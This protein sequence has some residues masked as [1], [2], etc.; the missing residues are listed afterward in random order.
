MKATHD[1][2]LVVGMLI[3]KRDM[4]EERARIVFLDDSEDLREL[5]PILLEGALRVE[6]LCF[7]SLMEFENHSEEVLRAKVIILDINLGPN[8]PDGVDAFNWLEGHGFQGKVLFFT[9]HARTNP[10]VALAAEK[11]AEIL[12]K[13]LHPDKLISLVRRS[14]NNRVA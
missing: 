9:G 1:S 14:L 5:M 10:Q 3:A 8:V 12:E 4:K 13:P 2:F 7:G 11:G 6:C